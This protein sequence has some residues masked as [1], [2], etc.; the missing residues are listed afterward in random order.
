MYDAMLCDD[1]LRNRSNSNFGNPHWVIFFLKNF[2][3]E[4][5]CRF[6][7]M[8]VSLTGF[9]VG[10]YAQEICFGAYSGLLLAL[11]ISKKY[12]VWVVC[13]SGAIIFAWLQ[14]IV[15]LVAPDFLLAEIAVFCHA[16]ACAVRNCLLIYLLRV[17]IFAITYV[18]LLLPYFLQWF[19]TL[20]TWFWAPIPHFCVFCCLHVC[21][22][23][24]SWSCAIIPC[25]ILLL[26]VFWDSCIHP[27][28]KRNLFCGD[29]QG[30]VDFVDL[31]IVCLFW[32]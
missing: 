30:F 12:I 8:G 19:C 5:F 21:L 24:T 17:S 28:G 6:F 27:F 22:G 18:T 23:I 25:H 16:I 1:P 13:L 2:E 11:I 32:L 9:N 4:K 7:S 20:L 3:W 15:E 31:V 14:A 29:R 10:L 26:L